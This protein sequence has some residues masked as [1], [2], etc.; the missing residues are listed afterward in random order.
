M[1][2]P[3]AVPTDMNR[4]LHEQLTGS[5]PLTMTSEDSSGWGGGGE[6]GITG[7]GGGGNTG[8]GAGGAGGTY[9]E[10]TSDEEPGHRDHGALSDAGRPHYNLLAQEVMSVRIL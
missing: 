9:V 6:R 10:D 5:T 2:P 1:P 7:A 4:R 3:A 8:G